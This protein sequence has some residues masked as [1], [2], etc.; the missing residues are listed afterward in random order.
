[1]T[2][3]NAWAAGSLAVVIPV[4]ASPSGDEHRLGTRSVWDLKGLRR[5]TSAQPLS[6]PNPVVWNTVRD[7][8][9]TAAVKPDTYRSFRRREGGVALPAA[10]QEIVSGLPEGWATISAL[11]VMSFDAARGRPPATFLV[12]HVELTT[13]GLGDPARVA[14]FFNHPTRPSKRKEEL[15]G[16]LRARVDHIRIDDLMEELGLDRSETLGGVEDLRSPFRPF[17]VSHLVPASEH[18]PEIDVAA[19]TTAPRHEAWAWRISAGNNLTLDLG[20]HP[21]VGVDGFWLGSTWCVTSVNGLAMIGTTG[22]ADLPTVS[23]DREGSVWWVQGNGRI[24]HVKLEGFAHR[25]AVDFA[26]LAMRQTSFL[27]AHAERVAS[28]MGSGRRAYSSAAELQLDLLTFRNQTWFTRVP[29]DAGITAMLGSFQRVWAT[30]ELFSD[31]DEEQHELSTALGLLAQEE[32]ERAAAREVA[33]RQVDLDRRAKE[34]EQADLRQRALETFAAVLAAGL[35]APTFVFGYAQVAQGH[36][37]ALGAVPATV[38]SII[39][40][41]IIALGLLRWVQRRP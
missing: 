26:I 4:G 28:V 34:T 1:M 39:G 17:V 25:H 40:A 12:L 24:E 31:L 41:A 29:E 37:F 21:G 14:A 2:G 10:A 19:L 23:P 11:E 33:D 6:T 18:L 3:A 38:L 30:T 20:P 9:I 16:Q 15:E 35:T 8:Q 7:A 22:V 32:V 36:D 13:K 5:R 27:R